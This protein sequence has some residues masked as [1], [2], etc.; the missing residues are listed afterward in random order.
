MT[1][2]LKN[3]VVSK[4]T[5]WI[6]TT[7]TSISVTAWEW[8]L[9]INNSVATLESRNA[10]WDVTKREIVLISN[11]SWNTLTVQRKFAPC[12]IDDTAQ[13]KTKSATAQ[14]FS[15]WDTISIYLSSEVIQELYA[16][17]SELEA[18][19]N[20]ICNNCDSWKQQIFQKIYSCYG[21]Y[22]FSCGCDWDCIIDWCVFLDA[23][24][25]YHFKNLTIN[26]NACLRFVWE[27]VP[28]I[29]VLW[30]FINNWTI[31]LRWWEFVWVQSFTNN[32][33]T[34]S[35][36]T[37]QTE[38]DSMCFGCG[39][40]WCNW[41][42]TYCRRWW[43]WWN[44]NAWWNW[45]WWCC[46]KFYWCN[47][48][49]WASERWAWWWWWTAIYKCNTT[50]VGCGCSWNNWNWFNWWDWWDWATWGE[51]SQYIMAWSSWWWWWGWY[52]TGNGWNWWNWNS[53]FNTDQTSRWNSPWYWWDWWNAW[54]F[55]RWWNW[56][57]GENRKSISHCPSFKCSERWWIWWNWWNWFEWW[58]G[59]AW[60]TSCCL[61]CNT[62]W[63]TCWWNWWM[64]VACWWNGWN[65]CFNLCEDVKNC[66]TYS[67]AWDWW[68]A[69][70]NMY[71]L[72][73][74]AKCFCN[75]WMICWKWWNWWN[76]WSVYNT[77]WQLITSWTCIIGWNWWKG[78]NWAN[79]M[80]FYKC[81]QRTWSIECAW[82]TWWTKWTWT[83][84][85]TNWANWTAWS[86]KF[87]SRPF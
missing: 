2:W 37:N 70:T 71:A 22:W 82:W 31:D 69:I 1:Y 54:F 72:S 44:A 47:W 13:N 50:Y 56:W 33:W 79:I 52:F 46:W 28:R 77:D 80:I 62:T 65:V 15:V 3:N 30:Q 40:V 38:Y 21:D 16:P 55:G 11:V 57:I 10:D 87:C 4:L 73:L 32:Y 66:K 76:W 75:N 48:W 53:N 64:W 17:T 60:I 36:K 35:N 18:L 51:S 49:N 19:C 29:H 63:R 41:R 23:S 81:N 78:W 61:Y 20:C 27:W 7:T 12:V 68:N 85:W 14:S 86:L 83:T 39:W 45:C 59:W 24:R 43:N 84:C 58:N 42:C 8:Q 67:K 74:R 26:Q 6:W 25:E 34:I 5:V 9:F